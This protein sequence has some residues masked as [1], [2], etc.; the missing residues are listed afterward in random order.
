METGKKA[1]RLFIYYNG[2]IN[3]AS[4][5]DMNREEKEQYVIQLYKE[6]KSTRE[7]AKLAHMSFSAIGAI[8]KK[9]KSEADRGRDP[10]EEDEKKLLGTPYYIESETWLRYSI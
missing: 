6:N 8:T 1:I 9:V 7:I 10:L 3:L 5:L 4:L 2:E